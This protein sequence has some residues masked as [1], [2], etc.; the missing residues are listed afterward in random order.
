[1]FG[2]F[3]L[4]LLLTA[5][6]V[7]PWAAAQDCSPPP[8]VANAKSSN[9]FTP[10]QEM[11]FGELTIQNLAGEIRFIRDEKLLA[12][13][14]EIGNRIA[15]HVPQTGL[16]FRFHLIELPE[17]NAFNLPGGHVLLSR[18]LVAFSNNEDE[19]AGV[20]AHELG[21][22]VVR[23]GATDISESLRKILNVTSLGDRK[24]VTEKYNLLIERAR[25]KRVSR[26]GGHENE[27]QLEADRIGVFAMAA[28]GYDPASFTSF[29]DRLTETGGKTGS[30][31]SDL[32]GGTRPEQKRL[33]EMI[34][35]T[36]Q[37]SPTCREG[38]A[39]RATEDFLAWQA[40]VVSFRETDRREDLPGLLWKKELAPKLRSDVSHF[41]F[42]P[43]G[44]Y[45]LAQ[46]DFAITVIER[47]TLAVLFQIPVEGAREAAFTPD[48]RFIVFTTEGLRYEKWS[49]AGRRPAEVRELVLRRDCWEHKLSPDGNYL[50]CVDISTAVN[51]L[52]TRTGQKVWEKK[53]FYQLSLFEYLTWLMNAR[54]GDGEGRGSFFRIEFSPDARYVM[55]SRSE[56]YRFRL[57]IDGMTEDETE[58]AAFALDLT[59]LKPAGIGGDLKKVSSRP[60]VF[61]DSGT[62][63][64]QPSWKADDAGLFSFPSGKRLQK[65]QF[66]AQQIKRT[67]NPDYVVVKPLSNV[68]MGVF[69]LKKGIL[70]SGLNKEDGTLW[71]NLMA[72]EA[73]NGKLLIREVSYNAAEKRFDSKDVGTVEIPVAS[74]SGLDAAEVS[75]NFDWL[76]L[77][78]KTRGGL[79]NLKTGERKMYVRG[80]KGGAIGE[81]GVG[82]GDFPAL[83]DAPHSLV[84]LN[85]HTE[86]ADAVRHLP[87]RGARQHGRF[88][89]LRTSLKE[90]SRKDGK[91]EEKKSEQR[92]LGSLTANFGVTRSE[93]SDLRR[94]VRFE[95]KDF[96]EDKVIWTRDFQKEA[97]EYSFDAY[98]GRLVFFWRLGTDAGKARLKESP[99]LQSK[100]DALGNKADDY[101]VEVVDAFAR[102][103]V[104][105]MLL[106]TGK[107]SFDVGQGRSEGDWLVLNDSQGRVLVYSLKEGELRHRFFGSRA[108][109][110]P[111]RNLLAVENFPGE[112]SLY[113]LDSGDRRGGFVIGGSAAFLRFSLAGDRLIALSNTQSAYAF[114]LGRMLPAPPAAK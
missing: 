90:A 69:D 95:L 31:F 63:L 11:I 103:V 44:K 10:E 85:P 82:V 96:V 77:S 110:N 60:Y 20:I 3:S 86:A 100:A 105:A 41:A 71:N 73:A 18:K 68:K 19:L 1:M 58:N 76:L 80:F 26:R 61:L 70:A 24:D 106:E 78:S 57:K 50:A 92:V 36:K 5:L 54:G 42:S 93:E 22:A 27:Q 98:S 21:H 53:D 33:R 40:A 64:G 66:S 16:R 43:D 46:D 83:D 48:G 94:E 17:A 67:A 9:L 74:I 45:L 2:K 23:H 79:W 15:R 6:F 112:V 52:D 51:L 35:A 111:R 107:G 89:L 81:D 88:V 113:D 75:D 8:I 108:A 47:E 72:Y 30:W 25:T 99:A 28:A 7:S 84:L 62:V 87:E 114:D 56:K 65:F 37:L 38:R 91:K 39:A 59:T 49:V 4:A 104:G 29:F 55:F 12:Y 13:V 34:N 102:N 14:N 101:L 97:P 32:F 109:I